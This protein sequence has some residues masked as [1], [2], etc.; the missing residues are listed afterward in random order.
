MILRALNLALLSKIVPVFESTEV[1]LS[2]LSCLNVFSNDF[3]LG[4]GFEQ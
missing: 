2:L 1:L 3:E 4:L